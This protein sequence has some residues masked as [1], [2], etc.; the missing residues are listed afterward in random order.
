M[1]AWIKEEEGQEYQNIEKE[2]EDNFVTTESSDFQ[3]LEDSDEYLKILGNL[4]NF[5]LLLTAYSY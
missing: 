5:S 4:I 2:F 3:K 1:S